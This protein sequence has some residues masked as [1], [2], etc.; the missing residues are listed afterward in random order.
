MFLTVGFRLMAK[1]TLAQIHYYVKMHAFQAMGRA[2]SP[3]DLP[4]MT[5]AEAALPGSPLMFRCTDSAYGDKPDE[6][7]DSRLLRDIMTHTINLDSCLE[8]SSPPAWCNPSDA[9][10]FRKL[11]SK[12]VSSEILATALHLDKGI[13]SS[14]HKGSAY[15][16]PLFDDAA[17]MM[18]NVFT[19]AHFEG[20]KLLCSVRR[21]KGR[22]L[23]TQRCPMTD[24]REPRRPDHLT[25]CVACDLECGNIEFVLLAHE[26]LFLTDLAWDCGMSAPALAVTCIDGLALEADVAAGAVTRADAHAVI[27]ALASISGAC[28]V[29][30]VLRGTVHSPASSPLCHRPLV[31][32]GAPTPPE[33]MYSCRAIDTG[34]GS[35]NDGTGII[36]LLPSIS[37]YAGMVSPTKRQADA[38]ARARKA[39]VAAGR[40]PEIANRLLMSS[41]LHWNPNV[42]DDATSRSPPRAYILAQPHAAAAGM[43]MR[44]LVHA[45]AGGGIAMG[46]GEGSC[47]IVRVVLGDLCP[48]WVLEAACMIFRCSHN[49]GQCKRAR[50]PGWGPSRATLRTRL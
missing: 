1:P 26:T 28:G 3:A 42:L 30:A 43:H 16:R 37:A 39:L 17:S 34:P 21:S 36:G 24:G 22:V 41:I 13:P 20:R 32:M 33:C 5:E 2:P 9:K 18:Q 25:S 19:S 14:W 46:R 48:R 8:L 12:D 31:R 47:V 50:T 44:R 40:P 35:D 15:L 27:G 45:F 38:V 29:R 10:A 4:P 11:R 23:R 49:S 7:R 6:P